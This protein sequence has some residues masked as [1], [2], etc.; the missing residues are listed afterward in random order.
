MACAVENS[1]HRDAAPRF[2][3]ARASKVYARDAVRLGGDEGRGL[4]SNRREQRV[5]SVSCTVNSKRLTIS[6]A[7]ADNV[8]DE[9]EWATKKGKLV[10]EVFNT[11]L[12]IQKGNSN[13]S[14][15]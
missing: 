12:V 1:D 9:I 6:I 13:R 14:R 8:K 10:Q 15:S 4:V 2:G 3:L 5:E 7:A 11:E